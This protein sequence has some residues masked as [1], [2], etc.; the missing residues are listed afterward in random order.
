MPQTVFVDQLKPPTRLCSFAS[1]GF[2]VSTDVTTDARSI[3][4]P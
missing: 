3:D 2:C 4:V 1:F